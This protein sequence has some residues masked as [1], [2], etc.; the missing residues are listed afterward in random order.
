MGCQKITVLQFL[1]K[2]AKK[3]SAALCAVLVIAMSLAN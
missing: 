1:A 2:D 3:R